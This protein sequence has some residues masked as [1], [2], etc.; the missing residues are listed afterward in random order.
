[1]KKIFRFTHKD[2]IFVYVPAEHTS[3]APSTL[4]PHRGGN[5]IKARAVPLSAQTSL[6]RCAS[7]RDVVRLPRRQKE[8]RESVL[9]DNNFV[10]FV[11][12]INSNNGSTSDTTSRISATQP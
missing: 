4:R 1:M 8:C 7:R 11:N 6:I 3:C 12:F 2:F 10:D 9:C 5:A